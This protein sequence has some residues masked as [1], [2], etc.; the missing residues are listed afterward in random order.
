MI[1]IV[2]YN[3][4]SI[5]NVTI[6]VL[7]YLHKNNYSILRTTEDTIW[8]NGLYI[9]INLKKKI[10]TINNYNNLMSK[11]EIVDLL[12]YV[13]KGEEISV[14][15]GEKTIY[16]KYVDKNTDFLDVA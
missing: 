12:K 15:V 13:F 5:A 7:D 16:Y 6:R 10:I 9:K 4:D 11:Q 2:L 8:L 14:C 1:S 3:L